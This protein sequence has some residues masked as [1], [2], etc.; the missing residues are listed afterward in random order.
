MISWHNGGP[1]I[2]GVMNRYLIG[3]KVYYVKWNL[4]RHCLGDQEPGTG[5]AMDLGEDQKV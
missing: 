3:F 2:V 1:K 4:F 5:Y